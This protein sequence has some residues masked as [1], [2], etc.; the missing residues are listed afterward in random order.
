VN[1]GDEVGHFE[2][3]GSSVVLVFEPNKVDIGVP[4]LLQTGYPFSLNSSKYMTIKVRSMQYVIGNNP[5]VCK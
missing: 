5:C 2:Y 1:K 3:G 4:D